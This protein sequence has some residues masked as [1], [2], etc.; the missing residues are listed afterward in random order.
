[1]L[2][3]SKEDHLT[4]FSISSQI[5]IPL[6][7]CRHWRCVRGCSLNIRVNAG[8]PTLPS[9]RSWPLRQVGHVHCHTDLQHRLVW[10]RKW[11]SFTISRKCWTSLTIQWSC[12]N[13]YLNESYSR[14]LLQNLSIGYLQ[15][16]GELQSYQALGLI[17]YAWTR[18]LRPNH[19]KRHLQHAN[20]HWL[21][22]YSTY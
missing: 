15:H 4:A 8:R 7:L 17:S 10:R 14:F 5:W 19:Q 2:L 11:I 16:S 12:G 18:M 22:S 20:L 9:T 21:M 3:Y 6:T 1:M 13:G